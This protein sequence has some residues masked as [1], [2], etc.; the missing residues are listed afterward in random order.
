MCILSLLDRITYSSSSW[1]CRKIPN[2][3]FPVDVLGQQ[4]H[5]KQFPL[6]K[7]KK[8]KKRKE[9][10]EKLKAGWVMTKKKITEKLIGNVPVLPS[11][12]TVTPLQWP[13]ENSKHRAFPR[14]LKDS[15]PILGT[16]TF[17]TCTWEMS[18]HNI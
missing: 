10:K 12:S 1:W 6:K 16:W 8:K 9:K 14:G 13:G 17:K 7:K 4:L 18:L 3:P 5:I 15:N 11:P 2:S